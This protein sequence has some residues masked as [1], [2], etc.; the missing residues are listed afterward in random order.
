MAKAGERL[1]LEAATAVVPELP[2]KN[3][4]ELQHSCANMPVPTGLRN[5]V[6][7]LQQG[8]VANSASN[9]SLGNSGHT[10]DMNTGKQPHTSSADRL[11]PGIVVLQSGA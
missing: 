8:F 3:R 5:T 6:P 11:I 1:P 2:I 10:R 9:A 7:F 4:Q